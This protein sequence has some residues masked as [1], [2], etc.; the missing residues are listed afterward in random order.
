MSNVNP[1]LTAPAE[2]YTRQ[3]FFTGQQFPEGEG[4]E[5]LG[6]LSKV[7]LPLA[8]L[9]NQTNEIGQVDPR[10]MNAIRA[11]NPLIDRT[12]RLAP[13]LMGGKD[14]DRARQA[15]SIARFLGAP[16]RTLTPEQQQSQALNEYYDARSERER[17]MDMARALLA[18][19][20]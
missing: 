4:F 17:Q 19:A 1:F 5:D 10:F 18:R 11:V 20:G 2:Y 6:G 9:L 8:T 12:S 15:E 14:K 7:L 3:D 16:V 13:Q